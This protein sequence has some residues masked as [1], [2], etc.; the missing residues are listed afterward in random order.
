MIGGGPES[1]IYKSTDGGAKWVKFTSGLPTGRHGPHRDGRRSESQAHARVCADQRALADTG[2]YRSDDAGRDVDAAGRCALGAATAS[3]DAPDPACRGPAA[4]VLA[5]AVGWWTRRRCAAAC[6]AVVT[7]AT[8]TSSTS[9]PI[10][11]GHDLVGEHAT[12]V[13]PRWRQDVLG[14]SEPAAASTSTTTRSGSTRTISEPHHYRQRRRPLRDLGRRPDVAPLHESAGHAVL[15]RQRGQRAAVLQRVRR[16]A[17]QRIAVRAEPD[18]A[19]RRHSHQR[20]VRR[21]R[22]RRLPD[23]QRSGRSQYRLLDVTEWRDQRLDLRTGQ[24]Q[25][26]PA[27]R[28]RAR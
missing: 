28:G 14:R 2:F 24:S 7:R 26:D 10:R 5:A 11:P 18:A 27:A 21:R 15:P 4:R 3:A 8:T 17:G 13:E 12:R 9:I 1:G 20:L 22:R 19:Q 16:R 6:I 25:S 23:A